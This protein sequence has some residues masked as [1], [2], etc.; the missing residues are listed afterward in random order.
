MRLPWPSTA[1]TLP[2]LSDKVSGLGRCAG[3]DKAGRRH[4]LPRAPIAALLAKPPPPRSQK[5]LRRLICAP[6]LAC[7]DGNQDRALL[8]HHIT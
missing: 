1:Q 8:A 2:K 7:C 4:Y 5:N 3:A 6:F